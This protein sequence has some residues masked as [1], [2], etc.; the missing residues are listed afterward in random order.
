MTENQTYDANK[1]F[2]KDKQ[3]LLQYQ[4][5]IKPLSNWYVSH[6]SLD[7]ETWSTSTTIQQVQITSGFEPY[8]IAHRDYP[9]FDEIFI[10]CGRDKVS[11]PYE[12]E[13]AGYTMWWLPDSFIVHLDSTG[14]GSAWCTKHPP[15][16]NF[17]WA[18]FENRVRCTHRDE[19]CSITDARLA[20]PWWDT[21]NYNTTALI[22]RKAHVPNEF[23]DFQQIHKQ[24]K[25][26]EKRIESITKD[27]IEDQSKLKSEI[28]AHEET[29]DKVQELEV[30]L[31]A[32]ITLFVFS[33]VAFVMTF[34]TII[35]Y[36]TCRKKKI[37]RAARTD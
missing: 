5:G 33:S 31:N 25:T 1:D 20:K 21:V 24:W 18:A 36:Y 17:R 6:K 11:H 35:W 23:K 19:Y 12:L 13:Y 15:R 14:M 37:S 7:Y 32:L 27:T 22:G 34:G 10:G 2:P 9:L 29:K 26:C 28:Q 4:Y 8:Y 16:E 3:E 30:K